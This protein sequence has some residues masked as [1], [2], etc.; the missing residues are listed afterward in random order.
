MQLDIRYR[1]GTKRHGGILCK[2]SNL[3]PVLSI[4]YREKG[5]KRWVDLGR[6]EIDVYAYHRFRNTYYKDFETDGTDLMT[7]ESKSDYER[8]MLFMDVLNAEFKGDVYTFVM[9]IAREHAAMAKAEYE[10]RMDVNSISCSLDT[11]G[12]VT[13]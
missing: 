4:R 10:E 11:N 7:L 1:V 13:D 6:R 8:L 9:S 3:F 2:Q 12:W 5:S